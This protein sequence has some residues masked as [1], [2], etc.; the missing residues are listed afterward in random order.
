LQPLVSVA[1]IKRNRNEKKKRKKNNCKSQINTGY[2]REGKRAT[3]FLKKSLQG[4]IKKGRDWGGTS[5][6]LF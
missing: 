5:E 4:K 3:I 1:L 2:N 6:P